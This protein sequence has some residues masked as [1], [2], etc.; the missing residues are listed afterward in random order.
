MESQYQDHIISLIV[1]NKPGVL[2]KVTNLIRKRGFNIENITYGNLVAGRRG[3]I[4]LVIK[5]DDK[6]VELVARNL[7]KIV[8]VTK[9]V[10][11][12]WDESVQRELALIKI[13]IANSKVRGDLLNYTGIFRGRVIDVSPNT[14]IV[15]VTGSPEKINAFIKLV[16]DFGIIEISRTGIAVLWRGKKT[17]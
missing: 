6:T 3:R 15:E 4:N 12:K 13:N 10:R 7:H 8:E 17:I 2:Y 16:E 1:E 5:G 14:M 9:V 11:I